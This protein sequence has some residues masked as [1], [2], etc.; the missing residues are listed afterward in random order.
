MPYK[1]SDVRKLFDEYHKKES[2]G[3]F[4]PDWQGTI[5]DLV[6]AC[7]EKAYETYKP[8]MLKQ[9][10][11]IAEDD[12]DFQAWSKGYRHGSDIMDSVYGKLKT[13][14]QSLEIFKCGST[15]KEIYK[16]LAAAVNL[17]G[18]YETEE[19][20]IDIVKKNKSPDDAEWVENALAHRR[21]RSPTRESQQTRKELKSYNYDICA[22]NKTISTSNLEDWVCAKV[23]ELF[24]A[25]IG[26]E[27][28]QTAAE[29]RANDLGSL[30][31]SPEEAQ[32]WHDTIAE[33]HE[34]TQEELEYLSLRQNI[35]FKE[36]C[37]LLANIQELTAVK[38][39]VDN[40]DIAALQHLVSTSENVSLMVHG[41]PYGLINTLTQSPHKEQ[42]FE[43]PAN[44]ISE[45][46]PMIRL[47]KVT[48]KDGT[49][50]QV[51]MK[52]DSHYR[53]E[54]IEE[55]M[56]SKSIRGHGVGVKS[57]TVSYEA[58]NPYAIK[59]SIKAKLVLFANSFSELLKTRKS[60]MIEVDPK[61]T[62]DPPA[63]KSV[64]YDY[65]Y[66]DLALK[67]GGNK[68]FSHDLANP[69]NREVDLNNTTKLNFR[70]KAI[71]GW[72]TPSSLMGQNS[73][74]LLKAVYDSAITLNLTPTIHHFEL[75]EMGRTTLTI[76]YFAYVE[77][78]FDQPIFNIFTDVDIIAA[79]ATRRLK[80]KV[81]SENCEGSDAQ[82]KLTALKNSDQQAQLIE[83]EKTQS[84][85][86][87]INN[88][89]KEQKIRFIN[90]PIK[91]LNSY[92]KGGP[93]RKLDEKFLTEL[94]EQMLKDPSVEDSEAFTE[95]VDETT[96]A[97]EGEP[98]ETSTNA[99]KIR[100]LESVTFFYVSDLLDVI[101]RYIGNMLSEMPDKLE[102]IEDLD[103][104]N[105]LKEEIEDYRR[106]AENFMKFRLLLGPIEFV[107]TN[108]SGVALETKLFNLGD[109]PVSV[110][111]F[112]E[113]LTDR[114][115]RKEKLIYPLPEF[116]ND[117]FNQFIKDFLNNDTCYGNR[118]K[119]KARLAQ[120]SITAYKDKDH[121]GYDPISWWSINYA[122][123]KMDISKVKERPILNVMGNRD[124]AGFDG[125]F[126]NEVNYL[127]YFVARTQ[128]TELMTGK[129][130]EDHEKGIWHYQ[131]GLDRGIVKTID[132]TKTDS[133]G[134]A[135]V[136]FEQEGY[137]GL[138]QLR[139][140]YD[141]NIKT[142]LDVTSYP[143]TY[144]FIEPKGF[145]P[146]AK[147]DL[148]QFGI[149]GYYMI[150]RSSHTL[151]PGMAESEITAK[152]VAEIDAEIDAAAA[153]QEADEKPATSGIAKCGVYSYDRLVNT[154]LEYMS[155]QYGLSY[156]LEEPNRDGSTGSEHE[157]VAGV[158]AKATTATSRAERALAATERGP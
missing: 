30:L 152:W 11:P 134:L 23:D 34:Q 140:L 26:A 73:S 72:A 157:P 76:E 2:G 27:E 91:E 31:D 35:A 133:P 58:N 147:F 3:W 123:R 154:Q 62:K 125:G 104:Q 116:L 77:D 1:N 101:L 127:T 150:M 102:E 17:G 41:D 105:E 130:K 84:M 106:F 94:K 113:F 9:D 145:D 155:T 156:E 112:M 110:K 126:E 32:K 82:E 81:L 22:L 54:D 124:N 93:F 117:F 115:L 96:V 149:G 19:E 63:T 38:T 151:G 45:L 5:G 88:V 144:I 100:P 16:S 153:A 141:A 42:F 24:K 103:I 90:V 28:D 108:K 146:N 80:Y 75:D 33:Q 39:A 143:G 60:K 48:S 92:R 44:A 107:N 69:Q 13:R 131:I 118:A 142:F 7:S 138:Q 43:M 61:S 40:E 68:T 14:T 139:V 36:Q 121:F 129:R 119:Q 99:F 4:G 122:S 51:E 135:E 29:E 55:F 8:Q 25:A 74:N 67:T 64:T 53:K 50:R 148:T 95:M 47:F 71:I 15:D 6:R 128:P 109:I 10:P 57:F 83:N 87:L 66:I 132:L 12:Q 114:V 52:F 98:S 65:S 37:F 85:R 21:G 59:K 111:Y 56:D 70:L 78:F 89:L 49:E 137:D 20:L 136:R 120:N 97:T 86:S 158:S 46:Q 18:D 79:Q